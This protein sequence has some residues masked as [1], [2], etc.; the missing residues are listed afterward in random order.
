VALAPLGIAPDDVP[1]HAAALL[2]GIRDGWREAA[3]RSLGLRLCVPRSEIA[4]VRRSLEAAAVAA[5]AAEVAVSVPDAE[6][7]PR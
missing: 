7:D 4:T 2:A 1:R 3:G 6:L 5:G